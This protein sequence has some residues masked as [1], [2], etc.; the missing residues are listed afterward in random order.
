MRMNG[1][2][3]GPDEELFGGTSST[4]PSCTNS[5]VVP[6][7]R[8]T[9]SQ[10]SLGRGEIR[11][12][13]GLRGCAAILVMLYHFSLSVPA[14]TLPLQN[15]LHN[16]YLC[17]DLFFVLSGFVMAY[18]QAGLF[19]TG[20]RVRTHVTFLIARIARIYPLYAVI[21]VESFCLLVSRTTDLDYYALG[22]TLFLNLAL[23]QA[24]GLAP[25]LEGATWSISTEWAAYLLFPFLLCI[26]VFAS[27]RTAIITAATSLLA[28]AVVAFWPAE[29]G[30]P[31][32]G[33]NGPLDVYSS[34]TSLPLLRCVAE[35]VLGLLTFRIAS[36]LA[37]KMRR[38]AGPLACVTILAMAV[39][40]SRSG[41]DI[42]V[43]ALFPLLILA[44]VPQTGS[45]G[46]FLAAQVPY[47]LGQWSFSI[48]LIH[49]KFSHSAGSVRA[50]LALR[51]PLASEVTVLTISALVIAV[52]AVSYFVV[53]LP[54]RKLVLRLIRRPRPATTEPIPAVMAQLSG[55]GS[56]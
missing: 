46:K 55:S 13:T 15:M 40:M 53:E 24:W 54:L 28:V 38:W 26:S 47:R 31:G 48:Y 19:E 51:V 27:N 52:A 36:D 32:Q 35:F 3:N 34:A 14:N 22:R 18:S 2:N 50:W 30:F 45:V 10:R 11:A 21:T 23:V 5:A 33:R 42:G 39:L 6:M 41:W 8:A 9:V 29:V 49:D 20:Y 43:I 17:V 4:G 25:S 1:V 56:T 37:G 44:L 12:L 16:G 7:S